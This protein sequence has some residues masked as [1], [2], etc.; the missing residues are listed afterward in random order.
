MRQTGGIRRHN[1]NKRH[2][3]GGCPHTWLIANGS[4]QIRSDLGMDKHRLDNQDRAEQSSQRL[5]QQEDRIGT[6][7]QATTGNRNR[8]PS[9]A[10]GA[11]AWTSLLSCHD[12]ASLAAT[13]NAFTKINYSLRSARNRT[14]YAAPENWDTLMSL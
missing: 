1:I 2:A 14:Q 10:C 9:N 5:A 13:G 4:S 8:L 12:P 6:T 3:I 7:Q 11:R